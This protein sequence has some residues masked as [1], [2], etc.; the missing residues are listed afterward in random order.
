MRRMRYAPLRYALA[1]TRF[2]RILN[3]EAHVGAFQEQVRAEYPLIDAH[4]AQGLSAVQ[5]SDGIKFEAV[6]DRMWQFADA[7]RSHALILGP[8]F[9]LIHAGPAYQ[10][11]GPF[12]DRLEAATTALRDTPGMGVRH[13]SAIGLRLVN[14]VEPR[15]SEQAT[16][17]TYLQPWALPTGPTAVDG[18]AEF[19]SAVGI[20]S[21]K[22]KKGAIRVQ[23]FRNPESA[24][25]P[26]LDTPFVRNND[27]L[28]DP[29]S[30][31]SAILDIDH[32][33]SFAPLRPLDPAALRAEFEGLHGPLRKVFE[34]A[35]TP[36][37]F[38]V[39]RRKK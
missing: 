2:Q 19:T 11:H 23:A 27:W 20:T 33:A 22:T 14:L 38:K 35:A 16:L 31:D 5:E 29:P 9:L 8:D 36:Y 37:A 1:I 24:L 28:G 13:A 32:F 3:M 18:A 6:F 39:W 12:L 30:G 15:G 26:G 7:D 4:T 34:A 17:D 21:F 10:E 25:S